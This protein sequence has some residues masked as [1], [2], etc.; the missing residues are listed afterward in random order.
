MAGR[1]A[2]KVFILDRET[3]FCM[4]WTF[5]FQI[6]IRI[7]KFR[8]HVDYRTQVNAWLDVRILDEVFPQIIQPHAT[9]HIFA[10]GIFD[11]LMRCD[12]RVDGLTSE[13]YQ[14]MWTNVNTY[15]Y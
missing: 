2:M 5:T 11:H 13:R 7:Y 6:R 10:I 3:D 8:G 12:G 4:K 9:S 14:R 15:I 1:G